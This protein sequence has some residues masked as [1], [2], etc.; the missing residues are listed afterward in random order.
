[1]ALIHDLHGQ[2]DLHGCWL[3][4]QELSHKGA[5][6]KLRKF[7]A[8]ALQD[9]HSTFESFWKNFKDL[10]IKESHFVS[11]FLNSLKG[12]SEGDEFFKF[13]DFHLIYLLGSEFHQIRK[14]IVKLLFLGLNVYTGEDLC[15]CLQLMNQL[16]TKNI[17]FSYRPEDLQ[18]LSNDVRKLVNEDFSEKLVSVGYPCLGKSKKSQLYF[19]FLNPSE[20]LK[21]IEGQPQGPY[22][23][24]IRN[25]DMSMDKQLLLANEANLSKDLIK[26]NSRQ[27]FTAEKT[28]FDIFNNDLVIN[29]LDKS[30]IQK[31]AI[32]NFEHRVFQNNKRVLVQLSLDKLKSKK[33]LGPK[34]EFLNLIDNPLFN[35]QVMRGISKYLLR[36]VRKYGCSGFVI[37]D[38]IRNIK[39]AKLSYQ[40]FESVKKLKE[41]ITSEER[42]VSLQD[43]LVPTQMLNPLHVFI[44]QK[45][46]LRYPHQ[47]FIS[48]E[49]LNILLVGGKFLL[50]P[51]SLK[52]FADPNM[53]NFMNYLNSNFFLSL[54]SLPISRNFV[55]KQK[56]SENPMVD[57]LIDLFFLFLRNK[58]N[59]FVISKV[60]D[61]YASK[62][63]A[64]SKCI[65]D[66]RQISELTGETFYF[67][68]NIWEASVNN[69]ILGCV[70]LSQET[71][72]IFFEKYFEIEQSRVQLKISL[73]HVYRHLKKQK[74]FRKISDCW[75]RRVDH[76]SGDSFVRLFEFFKNPIDIVLTLS[77]TTFEFKIVE[78]LPDE[79][80]QKNV[81]IHYL[82]SPPCKLFNFHCLESFFET[83][84]I[85]EPNISGW[86]LQLSRFLK[87]LRDQRVQTNEDISRL[88]TLDQIKFN[89]RNFN[90]MYSLVSLMRKNSGI[91]NKPFTFDAVGVATTL[92]SLKLKN[93]LVIT[94]EYGEF[95]KVGG[96]AV[97]IEDLCNGLAE[98]H[99]DIV[100]VLPYYD[101]DKN[102]KKDYLKANGVKYLH[103]IKVHHV[104]VEY[105]IGVHALKRGRI[106]F[107]FIH[108]FWLFPSIY[109]SVG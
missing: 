48:R 80:D 96:L 3:I 43:L 101:V 35:Y 40:A 17:I 9:N 14:K 97:M 58:S 37:K 52:S 74:V 33:E 86:S 91:I 56:H 69:S 41:K 2:L 105:E 8:K 24:V 23:L 89:K 79:A 109:V 27:L 73:Q 62:V 67:P 7:I 54:N 21:F 19:Q 44:V 53:R 108:N 76:E 87:L 18:I 13:I 92:A 63:S 77:K 5:T 16:L 6:P 32:L 47:I 25:H 29:I 104:G 68:I 82:G 38:M 42:R 59:L 22:Q 107:Y 46:M 81:L 50:K 65:S 98:D 31:S 28:E 39:I 61:V 94:P 4:A 84:E 55:I 85:P 103:N 66:Q 45:V 30:F 26:V 83:F 20:F 57:R 90:I 49:S 71:V 75:I 10:E 12:E 95:V 99:E 1:M 51:I 93:I 70:L 60:K 88:F 64:D 100:V 11:L 72:F 36:V 106:S 78:S 34:I 15:R 102:G